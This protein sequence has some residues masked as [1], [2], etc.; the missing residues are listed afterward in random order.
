[1]IEILPWSTSFSFDP[2][3]FHP[4]FIQRFQTNCL[5]LASPYISSFD[6]LLPYKKVKNIK[7][8]INI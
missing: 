2:N 4:K 8:G 1:M 7:V 5:I 6:P 3:C